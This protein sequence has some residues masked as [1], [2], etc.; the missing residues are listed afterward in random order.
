MA[1]VIKIAN[2]GINALTDTNPK[3][4]SLFVNGTTNHILIKE[5]AR[6]T[7]SVSGNSTKN[8]AHGLGYAPMTF[9][10]VAV[11]SEFR[12]AYGLGAYDDF[13]TWV[14]S[15]NL[16]LDNDNASA[17]NYTYYIFYDNL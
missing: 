6:G 2:P 10:M 3:N 16:V 11:G 13:A 14:T 12:W 9:V 8:I 17:R 15:T 4:F 7:T 1:K 5:K